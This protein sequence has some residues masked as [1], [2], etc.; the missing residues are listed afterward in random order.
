[1]GARG[2]VMRRVWWLHRRRSGG[3]GIALK[4]VF[5]RVEK[6]LLPGLLPMEVSKLTALI[7]QEGMGGTAYAY[8]VNQLPI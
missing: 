7:A 4:P 1:M 3:A 6:V 8:D 5:A 2:G